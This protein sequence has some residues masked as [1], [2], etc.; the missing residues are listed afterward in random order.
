MLTPEERRYLYW[1]GRSAWQAEGD[2]VE[3]GPWLGGSTA[4][5]AAGMRAS[6]RVVAARLKVYDNFIWRAFMCTRA[7]IS[8]SPGDSFQPCFLANTRAYAD[9][10]ACRERSLPDEIIAGDRDAAGK[11]FV[12]TSHIPPLDDPGDEPVEVLF[13]DGAKSWRGMRHLFITFAPRLIPGHTLL[14][15]QDFKYWGTYWVPMMMARLMASVEPVHNVTAGTT[16]TFR[17][18][19][20]L[21]RSVLE[22]M[23]DHVG[24]LD[25]QACLQDLEAQAGLL[26]HLGD[27]AGSLHVRVGKVSFLAHQGRKSDALRAFEEIQ[28]TWPLNVPTG[29]LDRARTYLRDEGLGGARTSLRLRLAS[30]VMRMR[31]IL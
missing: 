26:A 11:R 16:L 21:S 5:L 29:Q 8:L 19:S 1:L 30:W 18:T 13:I 2:V 3:I 20:P 6:G 4:C 10:V 12:E 9:I 28:R 27:V 25:T 22:E 14:V 17:L 24:D 23:P 15:C 7:P 31:H